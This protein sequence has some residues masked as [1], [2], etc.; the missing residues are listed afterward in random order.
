MHRLASWDFAA[1]H[2]I[3]SHHHPVLDWLFLSVAFVGEL[4][5]IW[6]LAGLGLII[7]ARGRG[8]ITGLLLLAALLLADLLIARPLGGAIHRARPYLEDPLVRQL[9]FHWRD[10]SFPS[11]HAMGAMIGT[12]LLGSEY[13]RW[14]PYLIVFTLLTLYSRPYLG[15]HYPLDVLAGAAFGGVVGAAAALIRERFWPRRNG[16]GATPAGTA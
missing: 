9:G 14:L 3:N 15:M 7:F 12:I 10:T 11:G 2:W 5:A 6:V 16:K 8:R 4:S 13:R 1:L